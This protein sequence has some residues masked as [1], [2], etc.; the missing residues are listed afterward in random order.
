MADLFPNK[1]VELG[2][3]V[4]ENVV[5]KNRPGTDAAKAAEETAKNTRKLLRA[6]K[7]N[8]LVFT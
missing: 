7:N 3:E 6:S 1:F 8:G 4:P 5:P 2:A